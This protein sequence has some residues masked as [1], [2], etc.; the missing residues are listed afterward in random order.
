MQFGRYKVDFSNRDKPFFPD[1]ELCKGDVIDYYLDIADTLLPHLRHYG[2]A[3][4]RF[5]DGLEGE[6]FYQKDCPDYF[7][8]SR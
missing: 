2:V 4:Q 3:M 8:A 7:P 6:G 1:V 5:P